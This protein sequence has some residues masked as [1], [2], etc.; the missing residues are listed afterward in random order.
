VPK[1]I[2]KG[3]YALFL[4]L[5]EDITADTGALGEVFYE[6]G[7]YCYVGSAM[8][9]LD[10]R[11]SHHMSSEKKIHW[12]IDRLTPVATDMI[13]Y[14]SEGIDCVPECAMADIA[15]KTGLVPYVDGFGSSDCGCRA[16]LFKV[17]PG[18]KDRLV[19]VLSL[20]PY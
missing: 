1:N 6:A 12:H 5:S 3:T 11:I 17:P 2:R 8:K 15:V 20:T 19:S 18:G 4:T 9:G 13:A 16:H 10:Q 14:V 7:E